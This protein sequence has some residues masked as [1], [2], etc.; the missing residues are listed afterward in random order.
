[1]ATTE[2]NCLASGGGSADLTLLES[3]YGGSSNPITKT[4]TTAKA[5][6][7][8]VYVVATG[9]SGDY[10]GDCTI[11]ITSG[12][13]TTTVPSADYLVAVAQNNLTGVYI[14]KLN[15]Q[16]G[17]TISV[18]ATGRGGGYHGNAIMFVG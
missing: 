14:A 9:M 2:M 7:V 12:G 17:D 13:T 1:M 6:Y 4:Y 11:T 3:E 16:N 18:T 8:Y 15:C 5:G 10:G